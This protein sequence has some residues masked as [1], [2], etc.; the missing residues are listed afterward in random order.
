MQCQDELQEA[1]ARKRVMR[2][3]ALAEK[4]TAALSDLRTG[5]DVGEAGEGEG[6][7]RTAGYR[8]GS[9]V[10]RGGRRASMR[11]RGEGLSVGQS[12]QACAFLA[13]AEPRIH[14]AEGRRM[15]KSFTGDDDS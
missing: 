11:G 8:R 6:D 15:R 4:S 13:S 7:R 5:L 10:A 3:R 9:A 12:I 2:K 1:M 14:N